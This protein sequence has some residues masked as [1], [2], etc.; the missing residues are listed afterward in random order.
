VSEDEISNRCRFTFDSFPEILIQDFGLEISDRY[1]DVCCWS[2]GSK[3]QD[4]D[5]DGF[6]ELKIDSELIEVLVRGLLHRLDSENVCVES[7]RS[8]WSGAACTHLSSTQTLNDSAERDCGLK[9]VQIDVLL[10]SPINP[11]TVNGN[12]A[13][14]LVPSSSRLYQRPELCEAWEPCEPWEP[15]EACEL[16]WAIVVAEA[17]R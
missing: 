4:A 16:C 3:R 2:V 12:W 6:L 15:W 7:N 9:L 8:G 5:Q 10:A 13:T 11:A 14:V 17:E 1:I